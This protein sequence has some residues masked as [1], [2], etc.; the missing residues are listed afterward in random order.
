M[1]GCFRQKTK[2]NGEVISLRV[3]PLGG[4]CAFEGEDED[5]DTEGAF[6][7]QKPWKRLVVLFG[8][9]F[10]NFIF[11]LIT[12][13]AYLLM[14]SYS[15]PKVIQIADNNPNPFMVGD[16]IVAVEDNDL[17]YYRVSSD[18]NQ[19]LLKL[20]SKYDAGEEFNVTVLRDGKEVVLTVKN[21]YKTKYR[22]ITN[23]K[24]LEGKLFVKNEESGE[25]SL[26]QN[27]ELEVFVKNTNNNL[28]KLYKEVSKDGVITY[29]LY[30][31]G[32]VQ[33]LG[34]ITETQDGNTLG[35]L[36]TFE[37]YEYSVKEA[38]LYA[39]PFGLDVCWLVL[40]LLGGL[41]TGAT[42]V[43][44]LGGTITAVDQ[45]AEL[46]QI[47]LRYL[48][49]LLPMI[50]M[51]LAVFNALPFPALDGARMVFV[52]IE[53]IFRK[54]V[55]R[56]IEGKIHNIGLFVLFGLVILIDILHIFLF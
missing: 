10:F 20:T 27:E 18:T 31:E 26:I 13:V 11:G 24:A 25:Y 3:F 16:V 47:D 33:S 49:L 37:Y 56:E 46:T 48:V 34:G 43:S 51:N 35:I 5:K 8:G 41:F 40:K 7:K 4:Y 19:Q 12:S 38:F 29:E 44:D 42:A 52:L 32:E 55:P 28:N 22:Y 53:W 30:A 17:N 6:N 36:K 21:E 9:V 39:V 1:T 23:L 50:A 2:A 14:A 54:P 15:L 45:I